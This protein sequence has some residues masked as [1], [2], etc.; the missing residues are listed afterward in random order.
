[1]RGTWM[2][3]S[4]IFMSKGIAALLDN[5]ASVNA[6]QSEGGTATARTLEQVGSLKR[7]LGNLNVL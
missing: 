4:I 5:C 2:K 6:R 1:L 7:W 3:S